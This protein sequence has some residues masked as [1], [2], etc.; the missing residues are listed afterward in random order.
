MAEIEGEIPISGK[1][2]AHYSVNPAR[3]QVTLTVEGHTLYGTRNLQT[4][5]IPYSSITTTFLGFSVSVSAHAN[6]EQA[7]QL[8]G[9][10]P[11]V[12]QVVNGAV[13]RADHREEA[14]PAAPAREVAKEESAHG[15]PPD[16]RKPVQTLGASE[17][18]VTET[19]SPSKQA[20]GVAAKSPVAA[21]APLVAGK[22][23]K[24]APGTAAHLDSHQIKPAKIASK[25][26]IGK[27][28]SHDA[29]PTTPSAVAK[30][31]KHGRDGSA[32][33]YA[34]PEAT[35]PKSP[36]LHALE[37]ATSGK[38]ATLHKGHPSDKVNHRSDEA[39]KFDVGGEEFSLHLKRNKNGKPVMKNGSW[40]VSTDPRT[41]I[42]EMADGPKREAALEALNHPP[43]AEAASNYAHMRDV[44]LDLPGVLAD[45][46]NHATPATARH[47]DH[48]RLSADCPPL[49]ADAGDMRPVHGRRHHAP[50]RSTLAPAPEP[51]AAVAV[52]EKR[53]PVSG[54]GMRYETF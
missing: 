38:P 37:Q 27:P 35:P 26:D 33:A 34:E 13:E 7:A 23:D 28:A 51:T 36:A 17:P 49:P 11:Y 47:G 40:V 6:A 44:V 42:A 29:T 22:P 30:P 18:E 45:Q 5:H 10:L 52:E 19:R 3:T 2:P 20:P 50:L 32:I 14:K 16:E 25:D 24:K 48:R 21:K 41:S 12:E 1:A 4:G 15:R 43:S 39:V 53:S 9:W 54:R 46:R 8:Q 31:E